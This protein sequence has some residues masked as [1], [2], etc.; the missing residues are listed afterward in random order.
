MEVAYLSLALHVPVGRCSRRQDDQIADAKLSLTPGE[1]FLNGRGS[2]EIDD[3][4]MAGKGRQ[5][6]IIERVDD[7][8]SINPMPALAAARPHNMFGRNIEHRF[9]FAFFE[10]SLLHAC[11]PSC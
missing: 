2:T 7:L 1:L 10:R 5:G 9:V 4:D 8:G 6:K 3:E 11:L